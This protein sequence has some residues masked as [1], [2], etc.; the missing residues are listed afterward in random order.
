MISNT[1]KRFNYI[2]FVFPTGKII[3]DETKKL[4][5]DTVLSNKVDEAN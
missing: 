4:D 1:Y 2:R 5:M 3:E